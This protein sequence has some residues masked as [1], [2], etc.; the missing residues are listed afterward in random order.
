MHFICQCHLSS[1]ATEFAD[2][3]GTLQAINTHIYVKCYQGLNTRRTKIIL[4][5]SIIFKA[6]DQSWKLQGPHCA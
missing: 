5:F 4:C 2:I 1:E 3:E 6:Q